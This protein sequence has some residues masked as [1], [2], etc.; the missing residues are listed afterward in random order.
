MILPGSSI[1]ITGT[2]HQQQL[3]IYTLSDGD[4]QVYYWRGIAKENRGDYSEAREDYDAAEY[5]GYPQ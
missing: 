3:S 2:F 4:G 5:Y 1:I